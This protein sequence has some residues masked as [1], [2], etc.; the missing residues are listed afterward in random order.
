MKNVYYV[1]SKNSKNTNEYIIKVNEKDEGV[2]YSLHR[3]YCETW[4][5]HVRGE[6]I[7]SILDD[8]NGYVL[9]KSLGKKIEYDIFAEFYILLQFIKI[10]DG[11]P[12]EG[13]FKQEI[14]IGEF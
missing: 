1:S 8:G 11:S 5:E 7:M 12:Y 4:S 14:I 6:K 2:E 3:S 13:T 10:K 9:D